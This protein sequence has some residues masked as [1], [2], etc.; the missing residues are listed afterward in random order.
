[1]KQASFQINTK[2]RIKTERDIL[3][4]TMLYD[5]YYISFMLQSSFHD[6]H[7]LSIMDVKD[8]CTHNMRQTLACIQE[9]LV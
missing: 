5:S 2:K 4:T 8:A 7:Q 3:I 1:M 9:N 6:K